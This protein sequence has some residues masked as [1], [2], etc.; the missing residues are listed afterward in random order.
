MAGGLLVP[1]PVLHGDHGDL[2]PAGKALLGLQSVPVP[3]GGGLVAWVG[4][5]LLVPPL[6]YPRRSFLGNPCGLT[7]IG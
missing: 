5:N 2:Y 7:K 3:L 4:G 6:M 1:P